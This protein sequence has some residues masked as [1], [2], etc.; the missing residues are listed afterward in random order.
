MVEDELPNR[1]DTDEHADLLR[2]L[3]ISTGELGDVALRAHETGGF[4]GFAGPGA[5]IQRLGTQPRVGEPGRRR[6][7]EESTGAHPTTDDAVRAEG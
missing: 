6:R 4:G 3:G 7:R 5:R 1:I 2:Q